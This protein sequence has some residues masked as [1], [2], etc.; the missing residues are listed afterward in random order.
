MAFQPDTAL[1]VVEL[2]STTHSSADVRFVV[3]AL[4]GIV[5]AGVWAAISYPDGQGDDLIVARRHLDEEIHRP[6]SRARFF[7][8]WLQFSD[9]ESIDAPALAFEPLDPMDAGVRDGLNS[10]LRRAL[11]Q[12]DKQLYSRVFGFASVKRI[13]HHSPLLI[14]LAVALTGAIALPAVLAWGIMRAA[15]GMRKASAEARI[16]EVEAEI[17]EEELRQKK[18][19]TRILEEVANAAHE[20]GPQ[21]IPRGAIEKASQISTTAVSDLGASPLIGSVTVGLSQK[22]A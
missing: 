4:D 19:Q 7:P 1:L 22:A 9:P 14:E 13:E 21:R 12:R 6:K 15:A 10:F 2:Q 20:L 8:D 16:R 5:S 3:D 11:W 18:I 17:R